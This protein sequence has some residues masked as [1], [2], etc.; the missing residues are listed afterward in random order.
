MELSTCFRVATQSLLYAWIDRPGFASSWTR[1]RMQV[2][3][4]DHYR[5]RGCGTPGDEITLQVAIRPRNGRSEARA[6]CTSCF[7]FAGGDLTYANSRTPPEQYETMAAVY[8]DADLYCGAGA[9]TS[10]H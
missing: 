8:D 10:G 7:R 6:L 2:L 9:T 1:L 3:H 5:C 4:R